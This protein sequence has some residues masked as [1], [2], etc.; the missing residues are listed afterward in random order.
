MKTLLI[1]PAILV[2]TATPALAQQA[3]PMTPAPPTPPSVPEAR[4]E[5][6]PPADPAAAPSKSDKEVKV[7]QLVDAEFPTYDA[8]KNGELS[9]A[10]FSKWVL[11]LHSKA[12]ASGGTAKKDPAAKKKWVQDAFAQA[13]ADKSKKIS[14]AEMSK[15]LQG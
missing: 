7:A 12:E 14:K 10:E 6:T 5:P 13:D 3:E 1:I 8:D 15:F 9:Q 2:L 11:A 4:I